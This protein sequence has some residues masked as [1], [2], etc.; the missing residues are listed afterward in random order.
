[1]AGEGAPNC[2]QI[3]K[4]K[5]KS[6]AERDGGGCGRQGYTTLPPLPLGPAGPRFWRLS[7]QGRM[8]S[9]PALRVARPGQ[10]QGSPGPE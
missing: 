1:M 10:C 5:K 8:C 7:P 6:L 4:K 9:V 2:A 3:Q